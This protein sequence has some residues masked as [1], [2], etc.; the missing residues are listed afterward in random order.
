MANKVVIVLFLFGVFA[1]LKGQQFGFLWSKSSIF[2]AETSPVLI[3]LDSNDLIGFVSCWSQGTC[4]QLADMELAKGAHDLDLVLFLQPGLDLVQFSYLA[5]AYAENKDG[6]SFPFLQDATTKNPS[7]TWT[8]DNQNEAFGKQLLQEASSLKNVKVYTDSNHRLL[9]FPSSTYNRI[10]EQKENKVESRDCT[11][12]LVVL[13]S[14][15]DA[16]DLS[17]KM[18]EADAMIGKFLQNTITRPYVAGFLSMSLKNKVNATEDDE[19]YSFLDYFT[20]EVIVILIFAFLLLLILYT[21]LSCL[22]SIQT[23]TR[24]YVSRDQADAKNK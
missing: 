19:D 20:P 2:E 13:P 6:G 24:F 18:K 3:P 14:H 21:G 22:Y 1:T 10:S 15:Q 9:P 16:T 12:H 8:S 23:P 5:N 17:G 7:F 4:T 11:V